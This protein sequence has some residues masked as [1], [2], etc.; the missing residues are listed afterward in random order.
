MLPGEVTRK[1][2]PPVLKLKEDEAEITGCETLANFRGKGIYS[3]AIRMMAEIAR[4]Q[5]IRYIFMKTRQDN[6]AAQRG[7]L[8][9]G[10]K[11][12]GSV[13]LIHPPM[14]PSRSIIFRR[15]NPISPGKH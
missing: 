14:A 3:Y 10:L 9:A 5:K 4:E 13:L 12:I 7:I 8:K 15:L 6:V 1:D 11:Q 2:D